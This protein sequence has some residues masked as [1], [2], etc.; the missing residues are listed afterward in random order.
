MKIKSLLLLGFA[1]VS[2]CSFAQ[3]EGASYDQFE[4]TNPALWVPNGDHIFV[5]QTAENADV[6][7]ANGNVQDNKVSF[8]GGTPQLVYFWMDDSHILADPTWQ[9]AELLAKSAKFMN[10]DF[11]EFP[12][13]EITYSSLQ[14][15]VY[16]PTQFEAVK[17]AFKGDRCVTTEGYDHACSLSQKE[18]I[19]IDGVEYNNYQVVVFCGAGGQH[20]SGPNY[21]TTPLLGPD[22]GSVCFIRLKNNAQ[23]TPTG[24]GKT[25]GSMFIANT[26]LSLIE[27]PESFF[28]G[29]LDGNTVYDK[30]TEVKLYDAT[31]VAENLADQQIVST[32]YY[33]MAGI[34]S[35]VPFEGVNIEVVTY[36]NGETSAHKVLK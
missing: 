36:S 29:Y 14:F 4:T 24:D 23:D 9:T 6:L 19:T 21:N 2:L 22:A 3:E 5:R 8:K 13:K 31:D 10:S 33:N 28:E 1:A 17:A 27:S 32:K 18:N 34:E 15:N 11:E 16:V 25:I 7:D 12:Y 35:D 20:L 26:S 30:R